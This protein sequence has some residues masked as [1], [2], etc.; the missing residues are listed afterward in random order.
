MVAPRPT[1]GTS[2]PRSLVVGILVLLALLVGVPRLVRSLGPPQARIAHRLEEMARGFDECRTARVL[3]AFAPQYR[4]EG[5]GVERS[6]LHRILVHLFFREIDPA[7]KRFRLRVELDEPRVTLSEDGERADVRLR[8]RFYAR[9]GA[10]EELF[11]D[12]TVRGEMRP[13]DGGWQ[14]VRTR[15]VNHSER[16]SHH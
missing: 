6:D 7:T 4:D 8:A 12:A 11:W 9:D 2:V 3:A 15:E 10:E 14:L 13:G 16:R 5:S 1:I